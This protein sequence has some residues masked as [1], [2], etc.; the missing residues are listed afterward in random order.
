VKTKQPYL[1]HMFLVYPNFSASR[2]CENLC[3]LGKVRS[4]SCL[5][6][7]LKIAVLCQVD[8][9]V[10]SSGMRN[11]T[12]S[13]RATSP[14]PPPPGSAVTASLQLPPSCSPTSHPPVP[15]PQRPLCS[16]GSPAVHVCSTLS[17]PASSPEKMDFGS[18]DEDDGPTHSRPAEGGRCCCSG[19]ADC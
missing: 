12:M 3:P 11:R 5:F 1:C 17:S 16:L 18:I 15:Q 6:N 10:M 19:S 2:V 13:E 9:V 8:S 7:I 14:A 4:S